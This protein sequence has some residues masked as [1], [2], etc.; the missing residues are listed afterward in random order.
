MGSHQ[1]SS[2][3]AFGVGGSR[4]QQMHQHVLMS[5]SQIP[6][7]QILGEVPADKAYEDD[8]HLLGKTQCRSIAYSVAGAGPLNASPQLPTKIRG[9]KQH[10]QVRM[11]H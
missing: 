10:S 1:G 9:G 8:Q 3:S 11:C 2:G 6:P 7:D 4:Q 5:S